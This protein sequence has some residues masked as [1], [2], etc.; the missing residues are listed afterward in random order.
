MSPIAPVTTFVLPRYRTNMT[1]SQTPR[2]ERTTP[3]LLTFT[4]PLVLHCASLTT[5]LT[6]RCQN[7]HLTSGQSPPAPRIDA[8]TSPVPWIRSRSPCR[9]NS[10]ECSPCSPPC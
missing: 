1:T 9:L 7:R 4:A 5:P 3:Y 2:L 10:R 6:S 8:D